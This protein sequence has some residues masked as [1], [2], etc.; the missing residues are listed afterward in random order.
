MN[1]ERILLRLPQGTLERIDACLKDCET[2]SDFL[3]DALEEEIGRR[4]RE[5]RRLRSR[6]KS[7]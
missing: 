7:E 6:P 3:R 2:R 4:E 5:T 1:F